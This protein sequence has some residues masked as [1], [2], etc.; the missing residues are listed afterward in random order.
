MTNA[1]A[2]IAAE[3]ADARRAVDL[4]YT[5]PAAADRLARRVTRL[6][7]DPAVLAVAARAS[8]M[9]ATALGDLAGAAEHLR[10][11]AM[12]ADRSGRLDI[13]AEV[14]LSTGWLLALRGEPDAAM[15]E[16]DV[17]AA[18]LTGI[19]RARATMLRGLVLS[20][21]GR[22]DD[23]EREFSRALTLLARAGGDR[24]LD[25]DIR[26]NRSINALNQGRLRSADRDLQAAQ[27]GYHAVGHRGR[28]AMV[29]HN[30]A[31]L[32]ELLG[33]LPEA[34]R[35]FDEAEESYQA[36]GRPPGLLPVERA[37]AL[38]AAMLVPEA[39]AAAERAAAEFLE[40]GNRTDAVQALI[41]VA[42]SALLGED[43]VAAKRAALDAR[44]E[45]LR[46]HRPTWAALAG[47]TAVQADVDTGQISPT[48]RR[49]AAACHRALRE[50]DRPRTADDLALLR[51]RIALADR[52]PQ[53]ARALLA[54][55][56]ARRGRGPAD[57]RVRAWHAE[58][59]VRLAE[60]RPAAA[61]RALLAGLRV[62]DE[63][64]AALGALELR[65]TAAGHG[66]ELARS[67]LELAWPVVIRPG[68]WNGPNGGGRPDCG[69]RPRR[70]PT[71]CWPS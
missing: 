63:F 10:L 52:R 30:Q 20:E 5:D 67:G 62:L 45:A 39:R 21:V 28:Q 4:A 57:L 51:A 42:R 53:R 8:G 23:A 66:A 41:L 44:R 69:C 14:A 31:L 68:C 9:A 3:P 19:D 35:L 13:R 47:F 40:A 71:R 58:A 36:A 34:L 32:A 25:A 15:D 55:L 7:T 48:T 12:L 17:A 24:L 60:G 50:S 43:P 22:G 46:Q 6:A 65:A 1:D 29:R 54:E 37:A 64:K 59:L 38:L 18:G 26:T 33:D 27:R 70:R 11:A 56:R 61:R 16:T 2:R 49:L